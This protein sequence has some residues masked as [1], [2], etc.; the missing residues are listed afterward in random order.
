MSFFILGINHKT[1]SV[2]VRERLAFPD[3]AD[4]LAVARKTC[5][6]DEIFILATCNRTEIYCAYPRHSLIVEESLMRWL[7]EYSGVPLK[8]IA[9]NAYRYYDI[10]ALSH[11]AEVAAGMD[12]MVFGEPQV[13][14]QVKAAIVQASKNNAIGMLFNPFWQKGLEIAKQIRTHTAIG[15]YPASIASVAV[16]LAQ[17]IFTDIAHKKILLVGAGEMIKL[18]AQY[19]YAHQTEQ[20]T[21]INRTAVHGQ[22][23]ADRVNGRVRPLS[24]LP[25]ELPSVDIVMTATDSQLPIIGVGMIKKVLRHRPQPLFIIDLAIPRDVE[26]QVNELDNAYLYNI[27]DLATVIAQNEEKRN[28][29][30]HQAKVIIERGVKDFYFHSEDMDVKAL[31]ANYRQQSI[32]IRDREIAKYISKLGGDANAE[33]VLRD[34]AQSLTNK[35]IHAPTRQLR[36]S[37]P[38]DRPNLIKFARQWITDDRQ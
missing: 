19:F 16:K 13:M 34:M 25:D 31:I 18:C 38:E 26:G 36:K 14:G 3:T 37:A 30:I 1:A 11:F 27:D 2:E 21:I 7:A 8:T 32:A 20:I 10:L 17:Y 15:Q 5:G 23:I 33:K 35:L 22:S 12:S 24:A 28:K 6:V 4:A 29:E 9:T